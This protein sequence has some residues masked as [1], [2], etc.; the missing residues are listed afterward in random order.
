MY[1]AG[2]KNR[3]LLFTAHW[4]APVETGPPVDISAV[5]TLSYEV[6]NAYAWLLPH[7]NRTVVPCCRALPVFLEQGHGHFIQVTSIGGRGTAPG[8]AAYQSAKF[9]VEGFS[10]VLND[11][12]S[13]LG[14]KVTC[15]EPGL[16]RTDW[17]GPSMTVRPYRAA[18]EPALGPLVRH[19]ADMRRREPIDLAKVARVFLEVADMDE[20][21]LHLVLGRD[22]V[23]RVARQTAVI[24][25]S[26]ARWA[27]LGRSVD[28]AEDEAAQDAQRPA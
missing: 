3:T 5:F 25:A 19:L 4:V 12:V 26:D 18:Y 1:P 22:A 7:W 10:G 2:E 9:A 6:P 21:P 24:T 11:E 23:D 28:F 15:A 16:M 14:V 17:S 13:S 27:P 8:V 20:P